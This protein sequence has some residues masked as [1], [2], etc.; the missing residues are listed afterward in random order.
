MKIHMHRDAT[1]ADL[2]VLRE[3]E[4]VVTHQEGDQH[5]WETSKGSETSTLGP[6]AHDNK[7]NCCN[8]GTGDTS[9]S[10]GY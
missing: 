8:R 10:L 2:N 7:S 4:C 5:L 9:N 1:H 3:L 6:V